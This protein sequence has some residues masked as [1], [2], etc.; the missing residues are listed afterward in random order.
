MWKCTL[1]IA[2]TLGLPGLAYLT[3]KCTYGEVKASG[4]L[5]PR[6]KVKADA[7]R[8]ALKG[9]LQNEGDEEWCLSDEQK[10]TVESMIR[11]SN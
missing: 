2:A 3:T 5:E 7:R 1:G 9:W 4:A 6:E 11:V 10:M 8:L